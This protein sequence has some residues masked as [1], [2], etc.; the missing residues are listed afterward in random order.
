MN[1]YGQI[2]IA[3]WTAFCALSALEGCSAA[4]CFAN[5][6]MPKIVQVDDPSA[7]TAPNIGV[8]IAASEP[9]NALFTGGGIT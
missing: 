8:A 4:D 2:K 3:L 1:K 7:Q 9:L 5:Q 6:R